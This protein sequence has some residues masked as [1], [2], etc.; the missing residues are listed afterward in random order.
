MS[1]DKDENLPRKIAESTRGRPFAEGNPGRPRGSK[2]KAT[3]VA[4]ALIAGEE[5]GL[6]RKAIELAKA[7]DA[8]MLKFFLDRLLPKERLIKIDLP[9]LDY[10]D[11]VI[12]GMAAITS[13]I[14]EGQITPSEGAALSSMLARYSRTLEIAE[15][16]KRIDALE[17][18]LNPE[19]RK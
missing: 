15:L 1:Q 7:G 16:S 4:Q 3:A 5:E 10:A 19:E 17:A 6:V 11:D 13:S 14:A 18:G 9:R 12:D 2:N 8:Q